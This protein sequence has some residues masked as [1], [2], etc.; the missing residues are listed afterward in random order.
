MNFLIAVMIYLLAQFGNTPANNTLY[1][2]VWGPFGEYKIDNVESYV[3]S[4]VAMPE[5]QFSDGVKDSCQIYLTVIRFT[6]GVLA[7]ELERACQV[8]QHDY[9][10]V[11][12]PSIYGMVRVE[13]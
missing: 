5:K 10:A 2:H 1:A 6:D 11:F 8:M 7:L 4:S 9:L 12:V 3:D 13:Y